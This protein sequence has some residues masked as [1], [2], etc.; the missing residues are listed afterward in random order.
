[1]RAMI[2]TLGLISA[3]TA[4]GSVNPI[5]MARVAALSP[6]EADPAVMGVEI[7]LPEGLVLPKNGAKIRFFSERSDTGQSVSEDF[8]LHSSG[9][10]MFEFAR[11]DLDRLRNTQTLVKAWEDAAPRENSGGITVLVSPCIVGDGP[12]ADARGSLRVRLDK[13]GRFYPLIVNGRLSEVVGA[14]DL[15][16]LPQCTGPQ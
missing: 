12:S 11:S 8:V 2:C 10:T 13:S 9:G 14:E 5:T 15:S 6:L 3:L 7:D 4:C 1:M 16:V